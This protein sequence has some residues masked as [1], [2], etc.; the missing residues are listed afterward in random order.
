MPIFTD[1]SCLV[2]SLFVARFVKSLLTRRQGHIA[3]RIGQHSWTTAVHCFGFTV[4]GARQSSIKN[5]NSYPLD[6]TFDSTTTSSEKPHQRLSKRPSMP[7]EAEMHTHTDNSN[8][9]NNRASKRRAY[10]ESETIVLE[11]SNKLRQMIAA[12]EATKSKKKPHFQEILLW[13]DSFNS[14]ISHPIGVELF[15]QFLRSEHSE[16]SIKFWCACEEF[17]SCRFRMQTKARRIFRNFIQVDAASQVNL[18]YK[19]RYQIEQTIKTPNKFMFDEA[20]HKIKYLMMNDSYPRFLKSPVYKSL[21][22]KA[23]QSN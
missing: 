4:M 5:T 2:E 6:L 18:D 8:I 21:E 11:D 22:Q 23:L 19:E 12:K 7:S 3:I 16:E 17:R 15:R 10:S 20:Q 9:P 1:E 13:K 14:L